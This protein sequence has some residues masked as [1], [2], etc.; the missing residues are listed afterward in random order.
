MSNKS[1]FLQAL[2]QLDDAG[3]KLAELNVK[4]ASMETIYHRAPMIDPLDNPAFGPDRTSTHV[5]HGQNIGRLL[6]GLGGAALGGFAGHELGGA[7]D[8]V[9]L[10]HLV[11]SHGGALLGTAAGAAA[12]AIPG[13]A[14][15]H[16]LGGGIARMTSTPEEQAAE[17]I[18]RLDPASGLAHIRMI[19]QSGRVSPSV[20]QA[21][22]DSYNTRRTGIQTQM[23]AGVAIPPGKT[24]VHV[25][26]NRPE[27]L[28]V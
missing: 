3:T 14:V 10:S 7:V 8:N 20:V 1:L 4:M 24:P 5:E 27:A 16:S 18:K 9:G 15:G 28:P 11:G 13:A 2:E 19:E 22:K 23:G 17:H 26:P 25:V 21:M 12:G 6:G